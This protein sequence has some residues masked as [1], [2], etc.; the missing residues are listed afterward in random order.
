[1]AKFRSVESRVYPTL[2]LTLEANDVVDLPDDTDVAYLVKI[3]TK[4]AKADPV[5]AVAPVDDDTATTA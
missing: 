3:D 1:M 2:A 4:P 5:P